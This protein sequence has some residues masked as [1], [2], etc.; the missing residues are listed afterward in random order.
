MRF[1]ANVETEWRSARLT[2]ATFNY[3]SNLLRPGQK[4]TLY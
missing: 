4:Q 1:M 3:F 2:E